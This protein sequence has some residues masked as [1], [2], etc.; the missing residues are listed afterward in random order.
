MANLKIPMEGKIEIELS[1]EAKDILLRFISAVE[2][3]QGTTIDITRPN[4]RMVGIDAF[5][6][7]QFEKEEGNED[8]TLPSSD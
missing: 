8:G 2:L 4:V 1:E 6:R 7:P 5:G 3:L